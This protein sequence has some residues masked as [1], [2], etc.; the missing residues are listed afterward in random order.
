MSFLKG[1]LQ[2][3][4]LQTDEIESAVDQNS[5]FAKIL[6]AL[7]SHPK[8]EAEYIAALAMML[9]NIAYADMEISVNEQE[10]MHKILRK[11]L[12][13]GE[14]QAQLVCDI[15]VQEPV[16]T[17]I[18][19]SKVWEL[20]NSY[21]NKEEKRKFMHMAFQIA[22]FDGINPEESQSL[23]LLSRALGFQRPEY[24]DFKLEYKEHMTY[25][26]K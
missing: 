5:A 6:E 22:A 10:F 4:G 11:E 21:C 13:L 2:N 16:W 15:A 26:Q 23:E 14:D 18:E 9:G 7:E 17:G 24:I 8:E 3:L 19:I 25:K 20:L 12:D 1:F